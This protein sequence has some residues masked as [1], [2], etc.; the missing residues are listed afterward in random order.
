MTT[1]AEVFGSGGH[2]PNLATTDRFFAGVE[3]EIEAINGGAVA[4]DGFQCI[5]D[6]KLRKRG[7]GKETKTNKNHNKQL[8]IVF[9]LL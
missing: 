4:V 6:H 2:W 7:G 9:Y 3:C 1:V 8:N 5:P